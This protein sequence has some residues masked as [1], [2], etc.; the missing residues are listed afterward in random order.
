[1]KLSA[2]LLLGL[3]ASMANAEMNPTTEVNDK[4]VSVTRQK[5]TCTT[6]MVSKDYDKQGKFIGESTI[7]GKTNESLRTTWTEGD[8]EFRSSDTTGFSTDGSVSS[9][10]RTLTK[11]STK[12]LENGLVV[13]TSEGHTF[14]KYEKYLVDGKR[15]TERKSTSV[16]TYKV[17]GDR[18][19]LV[20]SVVDGKESGG[21]SVETETRISDTVK[22]IKFVESTPYVEQ[23]DWGISEVLKSEMT[24]LFESL[25]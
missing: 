7:K 19:I 4:P 5:I 1:M 23:G 12:K 15:T 6:D 14:T 25:D 13:E 16:N 22:E 21:T 3:V 17:D 18:R 9:V 24:C 20:K 11:F 8:V 2:A 10:G